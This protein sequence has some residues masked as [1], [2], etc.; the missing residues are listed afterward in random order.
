MAAML[1]D[2][3]PRDIPATAASSPQ[4]STSATGSRQDG[5]G[6]APPQHQQGSTSSAPL[7][8]LSA[9]GERQ[10]ELA[11]VEMWQVGV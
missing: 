2:N 10:L 9:E 11:L 8:N 6:T 5:P 4:A 1:L 7:N 3:L